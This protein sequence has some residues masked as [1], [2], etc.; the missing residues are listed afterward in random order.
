VRDVRYVERLQAGFDHK[1]DDAKLD[2]AV[3]AV[4]GEVVEEY[5]AAT[6]AAR[7]L[8]GKYVL[9]SG[10]IVVSPTAL[11][12]LV[13]NSHLSEEEQATSL[14][15]VM[16]HELVHALCDQTLGYAT[17]FKRIYKDKLKARAF[18][19]LN[20]GMAMQVTRLAAD[21]LRQKSTLQKL[22]R[23]LT[24]PHM[25]DIYKRGGGIMRRILDRY[26]VDALWG[27]LENPATFDPL[28]SGMF[29]DADPI[30][31]A[32][33]NAGVRKIMPCE[34]PQYI[35]GPPQMGAQTY[36]YLEPGDRQAVV[37]LIERVHTLVCAP[38]RAA[39]NSQIASATV[40]VTADSTSA[41]KVC[42]ATSKALIKLEDKLR[43]M[44]DVTSTDR[45]HHE[46]AGLPCHEK[47]LRLSHQG[48]DVGEQYMVWC[49]VDSAVVQVITSN[50]TPQ[51]DDVRAA[52]EVL[53]TQLRQ[54][55]RPE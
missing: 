51:P 47:T 8:I 37:E 39:A 11:A 31:A 52:F 4:M 28:E 5:V 45:D 41:Q 7:M 13:E 2:A 32:L 23:T 20:E 19:M 34:M 16:T 18:P 42:D 36:R 26:G 6:G 43:S 9:K 55:E 49:A 54:S 40:Y 3:D 21:D 35:D 53:R 24:M 46:I 1:N 29:A 15:L 12:A 27:V 48:A 38:Q 44:F 30:K 22:E 50:A 25:K 33:M 10:E 14:D 17:V